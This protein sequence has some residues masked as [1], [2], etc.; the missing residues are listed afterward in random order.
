[1]TSNF[2]ED[3][4]KSLFTEPSEYVQA[5]ALEKARDV[6]RRIASTGDDHCSNIVLI[7]ADSIVVADGVILEKPQSNAHALEMMQ[8]LN[9]RTNQVL[10]GMSIWKWNELTLVGIF[11]FQVSASC[12]RILICKSWSIPL[13][14][15]QT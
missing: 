4:D 11:F 7:S 15:R 10:T 13:W 12:S 9:G 3:F 5:T 6:W 8:A 14:K 1:M 2:A